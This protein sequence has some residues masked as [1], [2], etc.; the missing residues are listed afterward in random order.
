MFTFVGAIV[1]VRPPPAIA[2][3]TKTLKSTRKYEVDIADFPFPP[4]LHHM[5]G[6]DRDVLLKV[7]SILYHKTNDLS[8]LPID[9]DNLM[10]LREA[11]LTEKNVEC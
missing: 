3:L 8:P 1:Q 10:N 11:M 4:F 2:V 9:V 5:V 6:D 7:R